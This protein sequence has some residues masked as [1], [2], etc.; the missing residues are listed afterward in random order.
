MEH[1]WGMRRTL[2][3]GVKLY[4]RSRVPSFGRLLNASSSGAYVAT[5]ASLQVMTRVHI[6]LGWD[7]HRHDA[8][9]R[10]TAYVV[11]CDARGIG[12]E[13]QEFG[14]QP[15]LTLLGRVRTAP[16]AWPAGAHPPSHRL[17]LTAGGSSP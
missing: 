5:R 13:W 3:V 2:D 8:R 10:I 11:R 6:A 16:Q 4:V 1:R 15:V 12:I 17:Q 9:H 14:P 7:G